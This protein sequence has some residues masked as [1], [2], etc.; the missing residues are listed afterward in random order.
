MRGLSLRHKL[1]VLIMTISGTAIVLVGTGVL[2]YDYLAGRQRMV[3]DL[4]TLAEML[5]QNCTGALSFNDPVDAKEIMLSLQA[6][7]PI[8]LACIYRADGSILAS[9]RREHAGVTAPVAPRRD[10]CRFQEGQLVFF[11][12]VELNEQRIGTVHIQSDLSELAAG[13]R[14]DLG[15]L[16][17][18]ILLVSG[19]AYLLSANLQKIIS[20]P[21]LQLTDTA[22]IVSRQRDYSVRAPEGG[23]DE[24]GQL[25]LTFNDMLGQIQQRDAELLESNQKLNFEIAER[26][27]AE[28]EM[29][30][31]RNYLKNIIDSMP[32]VLVGVDQTGRVTQWNVEAEKATG[33]P[34]EQ[35]EGKILGEIFPQL[36]SEME[37]VRE[38]IHT[39]QATHDEKLPREVDGQTRYSNVTVYPLVANGVEGAVIRMDDVTERVRIEEMMIQS[40]KM[41]S[42]GG[43]AAGMAHE[44]NNPLAGM[45]QNAE[46]VLNRVSPDLPANQRVAEECGT[47]METIQAYAQKR[48]ITTMLESIRTSGMRAA[49]IVNNML[50]FSRK[51]EEHFAL[52]DLADLLDKT[53]ELAANDYDLKKKY[54]FRQIQIV[55]EYEAAMPQVR[56]EASKIQQVFLNLLK[57]GAQAMSEERRLLGHDK[58]P[59]RFVLRVYAKRQKARI[60]VEDN[61]PGM[62][63]ATSKRVFEPFFTT[64]GVGV[65]TGLGLSVSYFIVT[66]NHRGRMD[67]ESTLGKGT[68]FIIELPLDATTTPTG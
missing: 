34:P 35:A 67:L 46:V 52:Y 28:E 6:K 64:K 30:H 29:R 39:R 42:V 19:V 56:C 50:S 7:R 43:L 24:M 9:Y 17:V 10:G 32:S 62:D 36:A 60:E 14:Q 12:P 68:T 18:A 61:G 47:N 22:R 15:V 66:E 63:E 38:A 8:L 53:V 48:A 4:T 45:V 44:I 5:A 58:E 13:I 54:D 21:I 49:K 11:G 1:V 51:S 41:L 16:A 23:R 55:R 3:R 26:K 20:A 33:V 27:S 65:G 57:N 25:I 40:E 31:L 37:K 2:I 59:P